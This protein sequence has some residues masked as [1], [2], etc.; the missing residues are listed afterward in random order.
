MSWLSVP[1]L[2]EE[3]TFFIGDA[4][5]ELNWRQAKN[6]G[7]HFGT[8][9]AYSKLNTSNYA[10]VSKIKLYPY[11]TENITEIFAGNYYINIGMRRL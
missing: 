11:Q 6:T 4:F 5:V 9:L 2:N 10:R 3:G 7:F 8:E 1:E